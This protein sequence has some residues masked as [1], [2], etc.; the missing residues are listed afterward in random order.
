MRR[1]VLGGQWM[2]ARS[3]V[4]CWFERCSFRVVF[5]SRSHFL[6]SIFSSFF[7]SFIPCYLFFENITPEN[8]PINWTLYWPFSFFQSYEQNQHRYGI[9]LFSYQGAAGGVEGHTPATC[10]RQSSDVY[11]VLAMLFGRWTVC[12]A[13]WSLHDIRLYIPFVIQ[14]TPLFLW[15][16]DL[17]V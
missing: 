7:Q 9:R 16:I 17:A 6:L 15:I 8:C 3:Y 13:L 10:T 11:V 2:E 12:V 1:H 14:K 5:H 4:Q